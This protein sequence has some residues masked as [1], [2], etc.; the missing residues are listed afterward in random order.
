M[1]Q[2]FDNTN[3]RT[4]LAWGLTPADDQRWGGVLMWSVGSAVDMAA[5]LLVLARMMT[6]PAFLDRPATVRDNWPA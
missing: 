1:S 2:C 3:A 4:A 6:T 5:V